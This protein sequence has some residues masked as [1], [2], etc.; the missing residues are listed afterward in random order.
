MALPATEAPSQ[1][2]VA[3]WLASQGIHVHPLIPGR[4]IPPRGCPRCWR[5]TRE[6]PN[7][8]YV[9]HASLECP[10]IQ[11]GRYCHGVLAATTDHA[12]IDAWW[13]DMPKAGVGVATGKSGLLIL[14]VDQHDVSRPED[15]TI[16]PGLPIPSGID[17]STIMNGQDVLALLCEI[18]GVPV[19][20]FT[21]STMTVRTPSGGL[22]L[23]YR[24]DHDAPWTPSAG[25]LG[26][27][28]DVRA[29][30]SYGI[31]PGTVTAAGTYTALGSCRTV[32]DLPSW[33][34]ADLARTGH[35]QQPPA[36]RPAPGTW[37]PKVTPDGNRLVAEAF[38]KSLENVANAG[39]GT[40]S[41]TLNGVSYY[42]GRFV[43]A[44][45]LRQEAVHDAITEAAA[46][47]GVNPDERKAQDT[48]RRG[49]EAGMRQPRQIGAR[50]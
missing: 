29:G 36:P 30:R 40:I 39:G 9:G 17:T 31:A 34:A 46:H 48:I 16:L 2:R 8:S 18:R 41:D 32:A 24:V 35:R 38:R 10:C 3:H 7:P 42:L 1:P 27:Q 26:W 37:A 49:I 21:D 6:K 23:W 44:G 14:D 43:G 22:Q 19:P 28:L 13:Q 50:A 25:K 45:Y 4:K 12:L 11:A 15:D 47:A 5:G 20:T 33:L